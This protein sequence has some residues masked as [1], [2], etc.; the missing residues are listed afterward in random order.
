MGLLNI[1]GSMNFDPGLSEELTYFRARH[2]D[3]AEHRPDIRA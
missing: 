1:F 2:A 3:R